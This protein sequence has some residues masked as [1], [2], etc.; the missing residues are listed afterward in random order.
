MP[1]VLHFILK[2]SQCVLSLVSYDGPPCNSAF[3]VPLAAA[4]SKAGKVVLIDKCPEDWAGGNSYF[5]AG[6]F[7]TA[8]SGLKDVFPLVSNVDKETSKRIDLEA[9]T[10]EDFPGD[11]KR[12]A[13]DKYDQELRKDVKN[14]MRL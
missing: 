12:F 3:C 4:Q 1:S 14:R 2:P 5:A 13:N 10:V 6:K 9:C 8:Y 7:C 11:M